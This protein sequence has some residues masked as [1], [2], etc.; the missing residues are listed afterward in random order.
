MQDENLLTIFLAVVRF[1]MFY[2]VDFTFECV[3]A[4]EIINSYLI[5]N[6]KFLLIRW[7]VLFL[8]LLL[9]VAEWSVENGKNDSLKA[10]QTNLK[11]SSTAY[12]YVVLN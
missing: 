11:L 12:C 4:Y 9:F 2:K 3:D 10:W 8:F 1:I 5:I 7:K 6:S